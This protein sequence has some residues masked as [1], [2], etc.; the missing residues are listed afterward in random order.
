MSGGIFCPCTPCTPCVLIKIFQGTP[1]GPVGPRFPPR[2]LPGQWSGLYLDVLPR[3]NSF[4]GACF[5]C[6]SEGVSCHFGL[7]KDG[8]DG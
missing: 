4:L 7:E 8:F 6:R 5:V 2:G 3:F 1:Q